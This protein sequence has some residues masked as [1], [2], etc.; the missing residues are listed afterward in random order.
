MKIKMKVQT[1]WQGVTY[2]IDQVYAAGNDQ[3]LPEGVA[4][5]WIEK[6]LAVADGSEAPTGKQKSETPDE[7]WTVKELQAEAENLGVGGVA[8]L[9]TKADLISAINE[10]LSQ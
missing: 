4:K 7:S 9:K 6:G 10:K 5:R 1:T 3:K 8:S 2:Q